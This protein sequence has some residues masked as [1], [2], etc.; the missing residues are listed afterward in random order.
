MYRSIQ[1]KLVNKLLPVGSKRRQTVKA[2]IKKQ[3]LPNLSDLT[4]EEWIKQKEPL[5][6]NHKKISNGPLISIVVPCYNTPKKYIDELVESVIA[7][8]YQRWQLC[9]VIGGSSD[10]ER[11]KGIKNASK[12]DKRINY[13]ELNKNLG[14]SGNTNKG[15]EQALGN[16]IAF[17][18]HDDILPAWA[19]AE[20]ALAIKA[21]PK[22]DLFYSDEDRLSDDG[23]TRMIP[24]LKP[25]WSPD[26]FFCVNYPAHFLV[27]TKKMI[28]KVGGLRSEYDGS[29]DYDFILRA[30]DHKPQIVHIPKI[31]YHMRM[32]ESSTAKQ[33]TI[34][35]YSHDA[36]TRALE[37]YFKRNDVKAK[38]LDIPDRPSNHHIK[39]DLVGEPLVSIIIPFKDKI[40]LLGLCLDSILEKT[41]Y[42]NFELILI[43][44]NSSEQATL[45]YIDSLKGNKKIKV[46]HYDKPF[47]YS[48]INNF[49][50]KQAE[51]KAL[52]FL[53]NDTEVINPEWLEELTGVALQKDRGAVGA[54]LFYPD[55]TIQHAGVILGMVGAAGHIFRNLRPG[56]FTL[57]WLPDWPRNYLAVTGACLAVETEKFDK[58]GGFEEKLIMGGSDVVLCLQL[59]EA[60][61]LNVCWPY[62]QLQHHESQSVGSYQNFPPSDYERSMIYYRP[63][64]EYNDPYFNPNLELMSEQ[65]K[66]RRS[67]D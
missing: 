4:Y 62:A 27:T 1:G 39:Y 32:A 28:N 21:N 45:D 11:A 44:N 51:G 24:L 55:G 65:I 33:V 26:L 61:Y 20:V 57:F 37:E 54:L 50:R 14:I 67:Y 23:K 29:Q 25:G 9:L 48:A 60:G 3:P 42:K 56:V 6:V 30:L 15:I 36:G 34:K 38:V 43:S 18:D 22:A 46:Y 7:Q 10:A 40:E 35:D 12:R 13:I 63:Y 64:L 41:T 53:N 19:L 49:G 2:L 47:N 66:F 8:N 52:V 17:L 31:L 5:L 58:V 16:Y 59:Y